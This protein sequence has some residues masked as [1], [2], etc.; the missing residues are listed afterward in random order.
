MPTTIAKT[1]F[2]SPNKEG[3]GAPENGPLKARARAANA[4]KAPTPLQAIVLQERA[5][6]ERIGALLL[7]KAQAFCDAVEAE[8][9]TRMASRTADEALEAAEGEAL[10]VAY[11][12]GTINGSNDEKRKVQKAA[13]LAAARTENAP[14]AEAYHSAAL[15]RG[16]AEWARSDREQ[17]EARLSAIKRVADME[18][19]LLYALAAK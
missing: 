13:F 4:E 15:H 6:A 18:A 14:Y 1:T 12:D 9:V 11:A 17:A 16:K 2:V 5:N 3:S 19:A 7:E 10:A 8:T